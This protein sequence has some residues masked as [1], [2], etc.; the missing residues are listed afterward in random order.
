M[1]IFLVP[2]FEKQFG[3][4][5]KIRSRAGLSY[6]HSNVF[7]HM[8]IEMAL[9]RISANLPIYDPSKSTLAYGNRAIPKLVSF[10]V[11]LLLNI[12]YKS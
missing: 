4:E 9:P 7:V 3:N 8:I 6:F 11:R 10:I 5:T 12:P 1:A 2:G